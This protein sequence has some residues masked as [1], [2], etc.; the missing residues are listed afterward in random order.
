V[1]QNFVSGGENCRCAWKMLENTAFFA[2]EGA[3]RRLWAGR[4]TSADCWRVRTKV[5]L[6]ETFAFLT[7]A[8]WAWGEVI[9]AG[10]ERPKSRR[11]RVD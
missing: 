11:I 5:C 2:P 1:R 8:I 6:I 10:G 9:V 3:W 4:E 7:K